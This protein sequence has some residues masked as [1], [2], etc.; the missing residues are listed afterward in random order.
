MEN[1][2]TILDE[3]K[4]LLIPNEK[5]TPEEVGLASI[6]AAELINKYQLEEE[7]E[8]LNNFSESE[9]VECFLFDIPSD[10]NKVNWKVELAASVAQ[11]LNCNIYTENNLIYF[12]GTQ[13]C[14][15]SSRFLYSKLV[16]QIEALTEAQWKAEGIYTRIHGKLWKTSFRA[17]MIKNISERLEK[18]KVAFYSDE[19]NAKFQEILA[20]RKEQ[21]GEYFVRSEKHDTFTWKKAETKVSNEP[22]YVLGRNSAAFVRTFSKNK[23]AS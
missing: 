15:I 21:V 4:R 2:S 19:Q 11:F 6:K 13:S 16:N 9:K 5:S 10:K 12:I 7:I 22:A 3:V 18:E 14:M 8:Q 17:G 23:M 1:T 20:K